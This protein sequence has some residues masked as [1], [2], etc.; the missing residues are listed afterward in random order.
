MR[1]LV[2]IVLLLLLILPTL[3]FA[4]V[5][6]DPNDEVMLVDVPVYIGEAGFM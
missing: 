2:S 6:Y 4:E 1:K 5:S 3:S